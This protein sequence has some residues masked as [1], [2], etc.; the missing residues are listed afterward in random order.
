[1]NAVLKL[2]D[3]KGPRRQLRQDADEERGPEADEAG[4]QRVSH[5]RCALG[6]TARSLDMKG[7]N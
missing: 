5:V 4:A 3:L 2:V 6:G 1:M 7:V